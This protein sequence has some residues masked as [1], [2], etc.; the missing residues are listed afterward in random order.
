MKSR[1]AITHVISTYRESPDDTYP[2][3]TMECPN[4]GFVAYT[5]ANSVANKIRLKESGNE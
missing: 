1:M 4:C 2:V 3:L 5:N